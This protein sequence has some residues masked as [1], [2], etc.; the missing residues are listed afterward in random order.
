MPVLCSASPIPMHEFTKLNSPSKSALLLMC[1]PWWESW[2][3]GGERN[4]FQGDGAAGTGNCWHLNMTFS[5]VQVF[6]AK[7]PRSWQENIRYLIRLCRVL[8]S[9]RYALCFLIDAA[10]PAHAYTYN[11]IRTF[12]SVRTCVQVYVSY[13]WEQENVWGHTVLYVLSLYATK[14]YEVKESKF[15]LY[16]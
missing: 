5:C 6:L 11:Q 13:V 10:L 8:D 12:W 2:Q 4:A 9:D 1:L 7:F 16:T 3:D 15:S 14:T